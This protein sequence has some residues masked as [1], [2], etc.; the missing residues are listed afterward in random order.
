[1]D[2]QTEVGKLTTTPEFELFAIHNH[3]VMT[4]GDYMRNVLN[5]KDYKDEVFAWDAVLYTIPNGEYF[6]LTDSF[7]GNY[8]KLPAGQ[9]ILTKKVRFEDQ[10]GDFFIRTYAAEFTI[11]K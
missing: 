6:T 4:F 10:N 7:K 8:G 2:Y 5:Q 9:Y 11:E 1:M 3:E